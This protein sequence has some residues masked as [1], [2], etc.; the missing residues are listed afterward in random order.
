LNWGCDC[1]RKGRKGRD[2][3]FVIWDGLWS[4]R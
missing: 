3:E 1:S 4:F 2:K